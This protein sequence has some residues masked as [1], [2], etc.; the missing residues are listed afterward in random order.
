VLEE[1]REKL[2]G[3][4]VSEYNGRSAA[5]CQPFDLIK[6]GNSPNVQFTRFLE[7]EREVIRLMQGHHPHH[8]QSPESDDNPMSNQQMMMMGL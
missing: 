3:F 1:K 5:H 8:I 4:E 2:N 6:G 7:V